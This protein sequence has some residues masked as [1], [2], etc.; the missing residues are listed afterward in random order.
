MWAKGDWSGAVVGSR[1]WDVNRAYERESIMMTSWWEPWWI[2][3]NKYSPCSDVPPWC[4]DLWKEPRGD[5]HTYNIPL[6]IRSN[7]VEQLFVSRYVVDILHLGCICWFEIYCTLSFQE[8]NPNVRL[9]RW[10]YHLKR[11]LF[12]A[13]LVCGVKRYRA[14]QPPLTFILYFCSPA[15]VIAHQFIDLLWPIQSYSHQKCEWE[16]WL[17]SN[18]TTSCS[19][20]HQLNVHDNT[21]CWVSNKGFNI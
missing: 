6:S 14:Q 17:M 19:G 5:L 7:C 15:D 16:A 12:W 4:N 8:S 18:M 10:M 2:S 11:S 3:L 21:Y 13:P 1:A 9:Q 20:E